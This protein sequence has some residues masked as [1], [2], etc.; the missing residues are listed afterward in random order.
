MKKVILG[1]IASFVLLLSGGQ[2]Y[3]QTD[4]DFEK[5]TEFNS[6]EFTDEEMASFEDGI[7]IDNENARIVVVNKKES[8]GSAL[9]R[10]AANYYYNDELHATNLAASYNISIFIDGNKNYYGWVYRYGNTWKK[11]GYTYGM[12]KGTLRF[13]GY[14]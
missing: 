12:F 8:T 9:Q 6:L 14:I 13:G 2:F 3:A 4:S 7:Y 10:A 1:L 11:G 5:I